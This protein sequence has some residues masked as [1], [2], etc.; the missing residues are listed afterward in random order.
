MDYTTL[1]ARKWNPVNLIFFQIKDNKYVHL[2][3]KLLTSVW[4]Q[5]TATKY[6]QVLYSLINH[7]IVEF[8]TLFNINW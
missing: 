1:E 6:I 8:E 2:P 3:S 7:A 4:C 5:D